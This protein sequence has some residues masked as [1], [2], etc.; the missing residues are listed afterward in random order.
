MSTIAPDYPEQTFLQHYF[1]LSAKGVFVYLCI[2]YALVLFVQ[3]EYILTEEVYYNS[4]GEQLAVERIDA[5]L[6]MQ[7]KWEWLKYAA[8]PVV[9]FLQALLVSVCLGAGAILMEYAI[10]FKALF[11]MVVKALAV[12]AVGKVLFTILAL[13]TEIRTMDDLLKAD[14]FSLLGWIGKEGIPEWLLYPLSVVNFFEVLFWLLLACGIGFLL[15]KRWTEMLGFVAATY[16]VGLLILVLL[17][18]F[19]QLSLM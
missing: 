13:F 11:S 16:G 4:L 15:K 10:S 5:F 6:Q 12:F 3:Q 18:T 19:F 1:R 14:K 8:I 2:T 7:H 9:V 17:L